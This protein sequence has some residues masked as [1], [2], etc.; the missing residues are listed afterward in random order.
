MLMILYSIIFELTDR[1]LSN[2]NNVFYTFTLAACCITLA[3]VGYLC[4]VISCCIINICNAGVLS[5]SGAAKRKT[6]VMVL[7]AVVFELSDR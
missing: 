1:K 7:Q 6:M 3:A 4:I 2:L 5:L